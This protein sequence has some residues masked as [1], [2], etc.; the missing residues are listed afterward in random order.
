M[1]AQL[2]A[3][4]D[5]AAAGTTAV[6]AAPPAGYHIEVLSYTLSMT[7]A[8]TFKWQSGSTDLT[9]NMPLGAAPFRAG[10]TEDQPVLVCAS[11]EALN[12]VTVTGAGDGHIVYT[13]ES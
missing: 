3:K 1:A 8:G 10:G 13:I 7:P 2:R 6:V 5:Q 11:A 4:I 9:G 12:L